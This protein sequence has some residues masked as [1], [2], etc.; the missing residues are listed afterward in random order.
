MGIDMMACSGC[1][2]TFVKLK[3]DESDVICDCQQWSARSPSIP[4]VE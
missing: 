3:V 1:L 4:E 2:G